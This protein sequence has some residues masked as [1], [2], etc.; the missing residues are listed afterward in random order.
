MSNRVIVSKTRVVTETGLIATVFWKQS[1]FADV[2][3][4]GFD[5]HT[6]IAD[7][8]RDHSD[9]PESIRAAI[10]GLAGASSSIDY[11]DIEDRFG[12]GARVYPDK[13]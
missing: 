5:R 1:A 6:L 3:G 4:A 10:E 11:F 9:N 8:V 13:G 2:F 7:A 12:N